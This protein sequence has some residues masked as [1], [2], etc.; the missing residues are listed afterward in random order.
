MNII[1]H[2]LHPL[3]IIK[4]EKVAFLSH[5]NLLD[6]LISVFAIGLITAGISYSCGYSIYKACAL[7]GLG[8]FYFVTALYK[9]A[10]PLNNKDSSLKP[11]KSSTN[12]SI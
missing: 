5:K 3:T 1:N 10:H 6:S 7:T 11:E 2:L 4:G 8:T 12:N 9:I